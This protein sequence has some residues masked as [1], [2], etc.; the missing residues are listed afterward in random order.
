MAI[1]VK[2][3]WEIMVEQGSFRRAV[4]W[5]QAQA[6]NDVIIDFEDLRRDSDD[7]GFMKLLHA[8]VKAESA[9]AQARSAS[10]TNRVAGPGRP[11][12]PERKV[13]A[14]EL[15]L[16][17]PDLPVA[18]VI[19]RSGLSRATVFKIRN[20]LVAEGKLQRKRETNGGEQEG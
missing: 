5:I 8:I 2:A 14:M 11:A 15:F 1:I 19:R 20:E 17:E 10:V 16:S 9:L 4:D 18:E 13:M 12:P 6:E 7:R 3:F